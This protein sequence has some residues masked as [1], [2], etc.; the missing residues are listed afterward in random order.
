MPILCIYNQY[1]NTMSIVLTLKQCAPTAMKIEDDIHVVVDRPEEKGGGGAGLMG[2][3][4]MLIGIGGCFCS[5]LFAA[6]QARQ[7]EIRGLSVKVKANMSKD[8]P[9]RFSDVKLEISY[10]DCN[11]PEEFNKL[12]KIAEQGCLSVN[13]IKAGMRFSVAAP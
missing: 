11:K 2:G 3:Q 9:K 4:Y 10:T 7:I 6:A 12:L 13:T 1:R 8:A 5:T